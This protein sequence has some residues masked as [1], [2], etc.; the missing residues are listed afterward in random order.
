[1]SEQNTLRLAQGGT[2][3]GAGQE[4]PPNSKKD[5]HPN[6]NLGA[7]R[8]MGMKLRSACSRED[9]S[10]NT[11]RRRVNVATGSGSDG[12]EQEAVSLKKPRRELLSRKTV[13]HPPKLRT[14][15][16]PLREAWKEPIRPS[17]KAPIQANPKKGSSQ[18]NKGGEAVDGKGM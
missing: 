12:S 10:Q 17:E 3:H 8:I 9:D 14:E 18:P 15:A 5:L 11:K 2:G 16:L 7:S 1:M 4:L 13:I 6:E